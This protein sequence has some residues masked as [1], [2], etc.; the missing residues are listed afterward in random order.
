MILDLEDAEKELDECIRSADE[1][2]WAAAAT[3]LMQ[4]DLEKLWEDGGYHSFSAWLRDFAQRKR[5]SESLLWKYLKAGRAY[6]AAA[7]TA[8]DMPPVSEAAMSART[9]ATVDKI[10]GAD[11]A[12]AAEMLEKVQAGELRPSAVEEQWRAMRKMTGARRSRHDAQAKPDE[13]QQSDAAM[14]AR[15]TAAVVRDA[16]NWI[17]G[18]ETTEEAEARR[19]REAPRQYLVRDSMLCRALTEFPVRVAG[20]DR[21]RRMD[22]LVAENQTTADWMEVALRGVEVK[23]SEHDLERDEKMG[24]YAMF[25]DCMYI[26]VPEGL[27]E[28]AEAAV[29]AGWG[30]LVYDMGSDALSVLREPERLEAPRRESALMTV[31][32]KLGA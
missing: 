15:V 26:A 12:R 10:C 29:P 25:C 14:T 23:V 4:V 30:M 22:V 31:A 3:V 27:A 1:N 13:E 21:A 16:S 2:A 28:A 6:A 24:D 8:A 18:A 9:V 19:A 11:A 5:C 20:A 7:E 32:V 17:W